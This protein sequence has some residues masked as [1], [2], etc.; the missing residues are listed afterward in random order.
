MML[1]LKRVK[2]SSMV[3]KYVREN[4]VQPSCHALKIFR[5]D[6]PLAGGT[7][8]REMFRVCQQ[9]GGP[10]YLRMKN[11]RGNVTKQ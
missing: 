1:R 3:E 10:N 4:T 5:L 9:G 8:L 2:N 11:S 6:G 7:T